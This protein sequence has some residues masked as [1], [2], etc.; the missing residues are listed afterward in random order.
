MK[1]SVFIYCVVCCATTGS[2]TEGRKLRDIR[3]GLLKLKIKSK[4]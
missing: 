3:N 1:P 2:T 4:I